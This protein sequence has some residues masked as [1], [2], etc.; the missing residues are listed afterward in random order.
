MMPLTHRCR[1]RLHFTIVGNPAKVEGVN[2]IG[3]KR[4]GF[5]KEQINNLRKAYNII[6]S[7]NLPLSDS[8][9]KL[10]ELEKTNEIIKE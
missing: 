3:L 7:S 10:D 2:I 8:L 1:D 6:Y 5:N 4:N 9:K